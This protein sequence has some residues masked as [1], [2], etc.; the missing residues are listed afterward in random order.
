MYSLRDDPDYWEDIE[1]EEKDR[2]GKRK[3]AVCG[4]TITSGYVWDGTDTFCSDAC[5]AKVFDGDEGCV[6]ILIDNGRLAWKEKFYITNEIDD[7]DQELTREQLMDEQ[8]TN[9]GKAMLAGALYAY[10]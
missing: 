10:E 5:A 6:D 8:Y 9:I 4:K 3:C 2:A 1:R 7:T